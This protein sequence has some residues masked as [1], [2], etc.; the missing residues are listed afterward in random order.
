M[1]RSVS[2]TAMTV[3]YLYNNERPLF[4]ALADTLKEGWTVEEEAYHYNDS[5]EKLVMR[6][7]MLRLHDPSLLALQQKVQQSASLEDVAALIQNQSL[8]GV[9]D[10]DIASLCFALGPDVLSRIIVNMLLTAQTDKELETIT[11]LTTVRHEIVAAYSS[12]TK[13]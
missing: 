4:D 3:L 12:V 1:G 8:E 9:Q 2:V 6:L 7:E 10:S 5:E 13:A 11:A